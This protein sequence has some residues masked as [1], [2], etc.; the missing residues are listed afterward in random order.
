MND[1]GA[2]D[3]PMVLLDA[4]D[5]AAFGFSMV[6]CTIWCS[7]RGGAEVRVATGD[8]VDD[9]A[10][11]RLL[12]QDTAFLISGDAPAYILTQMLFVSV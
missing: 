4:S 11:P 10:A 8:G 3:K 1:D 7:A 12:I 9:S 2:D 5:C 6:D